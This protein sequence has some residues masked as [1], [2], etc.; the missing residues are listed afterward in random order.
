LLLGP[1]NKIYIVQQDANLLARFDPETGQCREFVVPNL[2]PAD[3]PSLVFMTV[4]RENK[5]IWFSEFLNDRVGRLDLIT[6]EVLEFEHGISVNAAPIGIV[7]GPD[8][9]IW[10]SEATLDLNAPAGLAG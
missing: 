5:S 7:V 1:D 2:T 8:G 10:F 4:G 3:G 6:D 9:N